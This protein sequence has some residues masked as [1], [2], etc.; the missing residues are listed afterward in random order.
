ME[1]INNIYR[2]SVVHFKKYIINHFDFDFE[3]N[4]LSLMNNKY[5]KKICDIENLAIV[6]KTLAKLIEFTL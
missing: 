1:L 5:I 4:R 6:S 2:Y 3:L